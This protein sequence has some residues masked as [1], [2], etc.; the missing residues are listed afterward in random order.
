MVMTNLNK[1]H[2]TTNSFDRNNAFMF[3]ADSLVI[4]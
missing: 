3:Y 2:T 1:T 4:S